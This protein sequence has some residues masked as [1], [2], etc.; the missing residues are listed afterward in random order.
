M[1]KSTIK[2]AIPQQY[3]YHC[4][5]NNHPQGHNN[6]EFGMFGLMSEYLYPQP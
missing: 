1:D 4:H 6:P 5:P 2:D 3:N